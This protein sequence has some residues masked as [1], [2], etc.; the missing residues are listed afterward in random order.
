[1]KKYIF[2]ILCLLMAT[3]CFELDLT[4]Q[5]VL[6]TATA[7]GSTSEMQSYIDNFYES[8]V[9]VQSFAAGSAAGIAGNDLQSD[10]MCSNSLDT[11]LAGQNVLSKASK[12]GNYTQI[13]NVNFFILNKDNCPVK[14]INFN[15][16]VGEAYYF[17][18]WY[19]YQMFINY[20]ELTWVETLL[21]P[22]QEAMALPRNN[23]TFVADKI[24]ADLDTAISYL[25]E[26]KNNATMRIHRDVARALQSEVALF[27][28]T[29]EKYHKAHNDAF[30]DKSVTDAKINA[31]LKKAAE[32]A[33]AIMDRNVWS[34]YKGND[35]LTAYRD[36]FKTANLSNN[37][38]VLWFKMYDGDVVGNS[39]TRYLNKGGGSCGVTLS[40]VDDYL[41]IAGKPF[42]GSEREEAQKVYGNELQPTLRDPRLSQ[43]VCLPGQPLR[44]NN[45]YV[46]NFPPLDGNSYFAN[47]TGYAMLKHVEIDT[48]S[49]AALDTENK[50][51]TPAIQYRYADVLLMYAEALA[52]LDGPGNA[53]LIKA[54]LK[55]LRDRV[56]MPG[57]D[58][59][60]EYNQQADYPFRNL[61]KYVQAVRRERRVEKACEGQRFVDI[62]RWAAADVL[63]YHQLPLGALFVGSNLPG[64]Y[65]T[66]KYDQPKGNNLFLTGQPGDERRYISPVN[67]SV[68]PV[69]CEFNLNRDYLLPIQERMLILTSNQWTQNPGW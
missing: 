63:V 62:C 60:R 15:Q 56:G 68:Y 23:R 19:Y 69:G 49:V 3:S 24:L 36:M 25:P 14:D 32:S 35:R 26:Q 43:T 11:R 21:D 16:F 38:E 33:K 55:P 6:S 27:E 39:V 61:D 52:E 9:R 44:P 64:A 54:A 20:G 51:A 48:K 12:L 59:D 57:V 18:A 7:F 29:W 50:G 17:R 30:Y 45:G 31:Y 1:M 34:I 10:N 2:I 13:R 67:P 28:G 40:L 41:T 42:I 8:G 47:T 46:F 58:F 65:T 22:T 37:V 66:L 53:E 4:P 5:G